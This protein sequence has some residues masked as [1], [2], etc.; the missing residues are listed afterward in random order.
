[1]KLKKIEVAILMALVL[2]AMI[3]I[4]GFAAGCEG[5][6]ENVL[7]L[8]V[9]ANSD[10]GEDQALKLKV[11]DAILEQG[12][13]IFDGAKDVSEAQAKIEYSKADLKTAAQEVIR[14]EGYDYDVEIDIGKEY[15]DTRVYD[16][17]TLPAGEYRAVR[18]IIGDGNG[19]NWWCVMFPPLCLPG[20]SQTQEL[21]AVLDDG[22]IQVVKSDPQVD[23]RFKI[24]EIF[25]KFTKMFK[26]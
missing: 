14:Q 18:I 22:G 16:E 13:E 26:S 23:A 17:I 11:R 2:T 6:K 15:F 12:K 8:H 7:R 19:K 3:Q 21:D 9:I 25:E 4:T 24:V 5:I 1:L 20:A 10:S